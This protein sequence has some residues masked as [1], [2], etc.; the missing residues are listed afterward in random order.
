[1]NLRIVMTMGLAAVAGPIF[2]GG[3]GWHL[4]GDF[5]G[6]DPNGPLMV[7]T[8]AGSGIF[9]ATLTGLGAGTRQEFKITDGTWNVN[10]PPSNSWYVADGA[11]EVTVNYDTNVYADGWTNSTQRVYVSNDVTS[12]T[13]VGDWQGWNNANAATAMSDIG[14]GIYKTSV[15]GV[16]PGTYEFKAVRTG[17]WDA[18]GADARAINASTLFFTLDATNTTAELFVN[19]ANGTIKATPV[20]EPATMA[21]LAMGVAAAAR[22]R[23]R[24]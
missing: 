20:P 22:R 13:A 14:G 7:E 12:W 9:Q 21:L 15:T 6:W 4:A 24:A 18:I 8:G 5:N 19:T 2:A 16:G 1:M 11:G 3:A 23:K 17:S 10:W